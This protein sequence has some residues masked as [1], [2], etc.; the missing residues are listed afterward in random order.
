MGIG[1]RGTSTSLAFIALITLSACS[2][3]PLDAIPIPTNKP[4][5]EV[6]LAPNSE[7]E[8]PIPGQKFAPPHRTNR[9]ARQSYCRG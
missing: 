4:V 7:L 5:D 6:Q 2:G 8:L 9:R 1:V 3:Y